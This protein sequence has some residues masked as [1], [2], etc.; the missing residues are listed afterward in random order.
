MLSSSFLCIR[1]VLDLLWA[2]PVTLILTAFE[3]IVFPFIRARAAGIVYEPL[4]AAYKVYVKV[5]DE[6]LDVWPFII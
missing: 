4:D 6:E 1:G 3:K 2:E 5:I